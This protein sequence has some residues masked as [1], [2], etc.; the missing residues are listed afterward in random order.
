MRSSGE[1]TP[2][3]HKTASISAQ[4]L[5]APCLPLLNLFRALHEDLR[6][7]RIADHLHVRTEPEYFV[8]LSDTTRLQSSNLF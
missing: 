1:T 6:D 3:R 5:D 2:R 4:P 7:F 8:G